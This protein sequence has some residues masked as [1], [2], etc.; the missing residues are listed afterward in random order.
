MRSIACRMP[1]C[2]LA[3]AWSPQDSPGHVRECR[4]QTGRTAGRWIDVPTQSIGERQSWCGVPRVLRVGADVVVREVLRRKGARGV[5]TER[6]AHPRR[7]RQRGD[8]RLSVGRPIG[9]RIHPPEVDAEL[10]LMFPSQPRKTVDDVELARL[11]VRGAAGG[12]CADGSAGER[13]C[14]RGRIVW[15]EKH[16]RLWQRD[17][18]A[19][20][21]QTVRVVARRVAVV[22]AQVVAGRRAEYPRLSGRHRV[23][24][25]CEVGYHRRLVRLNRAVRRRVVDAREDGHRRGRPSVDPDARRVHRAVVGVGADEAGDVRIAIR[26]P[27]LAL[28]LRRQRIGIEERPHRR[29]GVLPGRERRHIRRHRLGDLKP[30]SFVG[31][32]EEHAILEYRTANHAAEVVGAIGRS[33]GAGEVVEPVVRVELRVPVGTRTRRRGTHWTP[34]GS[35]SRSGRLAAGRTRARTTRS[36]C[37]TP[38]SRRRTRSCC[39]RQTCWSGC[40]TPSRT[41]SARRSG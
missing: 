40:P 30:L 19:E 16:R 28:R 21:I 32:E 5:S 25:Q 31:R 33:R 3:R 34:T 27:G 39:S 9:A 15:R 17:G 36:R 18:A 38:A 29:D 4:Q 2:R 12:N 24:V 20:R 11:V 14:G 8:E 22:E 1:A 35:R 13:P 10:H 37:G 7:R 23:Q 41:S 6:A 26:R